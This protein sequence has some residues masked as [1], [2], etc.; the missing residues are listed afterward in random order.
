MVYRDTCSLLE[1]EISS[2]VEQVCQRRINVTGLIVERSKWSMKSTL[3]DVMIFFARQLK[4][5]MYQNLPS[6]YVTGCSC[7]IYIFLLF[8]QI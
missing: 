3:I 2:N 1:R 6:N 7:S 5:S 8:V 4:F